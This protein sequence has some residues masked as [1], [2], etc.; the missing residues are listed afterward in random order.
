MAIRIQRPSAGEQSDD[1]GGGRF[2]F[3]FAGADRYVDGQPGRDS[4][5]PLFRRWEAIGL[6]LLVT[7]GA[8]FIPAGGPAAATLLRAAAEQSDPSARFLTL[9][10]PVLA[11][12]FAWRASGRLVRPFSRLAPLALVSTLSACAV[13]LAFHLGLYLALV[14]GSADPALR[15]GVWLTTVPGAVIG[16]VLL[17]VVASIRLAARRATHDLQAARDVLNMSRQEKP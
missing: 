11:L 7:V 2:R 14:A 8:A 4:G 10:P 12:M 9:A 5:R 3:S 6:L 1:S 16:W 17:L 15:P 13:F